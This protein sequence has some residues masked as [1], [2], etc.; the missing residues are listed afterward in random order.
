MDNKG[1]GEKKRKL[2]IQLHLFSSH[3][4]RFSLFPFFFFFPNLLIYWPLL[5]V[6][7]YCAPSSG[8]RE[9]SDSEAGEALAVSPTRGRGRRVISIDSAKKKWTH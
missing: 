6:I 2:S 7:T 1:V 5:L 4:D 9:A 3:T 8:E